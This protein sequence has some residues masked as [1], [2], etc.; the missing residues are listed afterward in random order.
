[1]K[2]Y[3][4]ESLWSRVSSSLKEALK[5]LTRYRVKTEPQWSEWL[6]LTISCMV[7]CFSSIIVLTNGGCI[8]Y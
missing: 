2:C 1:M 4:I 5:R 3:F 6:C 8:Y 7:L